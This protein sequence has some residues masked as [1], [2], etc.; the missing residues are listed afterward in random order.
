M[1][2]NILIEANNIEVTYG[3]QT[4]LDFERFSA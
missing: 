4:V 3:E 2:K 1:P